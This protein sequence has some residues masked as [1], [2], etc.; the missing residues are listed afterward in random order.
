MTYFD[1]H[2]LHAYPMPIPMGLNLF[3]CTSPFGSLVCPVCP[4]CMS[5]GWNDATTRAHVLAKA[6][7]L[8]DG[9]YTKDKNIACHCALTRNQRWMD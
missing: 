7:G 2:H 4:N 5:Y 6:R 8:Q 9:Y 3:I 1:D